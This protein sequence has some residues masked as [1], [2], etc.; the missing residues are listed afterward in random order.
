MNGIFY[1]VTALLSLT[2]GALILVVN[3]RRTINK[4]FFF[5]SLWIGIWFFCVFMAIRKGAGYSGGPADDILFWLRLSSV[6]AAFTGWFVWLM[7][8][9]L[10]DPHHSISRIFKSSWPWFCISCVIAFLALTEWFVPSDST[11]LETKRGSGYFLYMGAIACSCVYF[12]HD[13]FLQMRRLSGARKIEM[14]LFLFNTICACFAIVMLNL[15]GALFEIP[16]LRRI[17]PFGFV[18]LH[19][20]TVWAVS[21]HKV[22]DAK[23]IVSSIGQRALFLCVLGCGAFIAIR[24][25]EGRIDPPFDILFAAVFTGT[26]AIVFERPTRKWFGLDPDHLLANPRRAIIDCARNEPDA[27]E[28]KLRF[29]KV[30]QEWCQANRVE[31][32]IER[33]GGFVGTQKTLS[34]GWVMLQSLARN[35]WITPEFLQRRRADS[36]TTACVQWMSANKCGALLASPRGSDQPSLVIFLGLRE[37]LRPYTY[38]DIQLIFPLAELMDNILTHASLAQHAAKLAQME[39]AAMMSR[40]LAHDLR[41]LT[42]PIAA[43]LLCAEG[44]A[45]SGSPEAEVYAAAR[46]SMKVMDDYIRESLFFSRRL[47][48]EFTELN[49]RDAMVSVIKLAQDRAAMRGVALSLEDSPEIRFSADHAL[50]ERLTL[51]LVHNAVDASGYGGVVRISSG[52]KFE[53]VYLRVEDQGAGIPAENIRRIFDPYFTTKDTGDTRRGL[54]LGLAICRKIVDLHGGD[55]EVE[56]TPGRGATFTALFP[57][58]QPVKEAKRPQEVNSVWNPVSVAEIDLGAPSLDTAGT[59]A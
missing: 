21:S 9:V 12:L 13:A 53:K 46:H 35:S 25:F 55:I 38:P 47:V 29:E 36:A 22:F 41:N 24:I 58:R 39:S 31:L 50:F 19:I 8:S 5:A 43:Y 16:W 59:S 14:Q 56:S 37:S 44:R 26:L 33:D 54:G 23:Q 30:I 27:A 2:N 15:G 28:L 51:N 49:P 20:L 40:S 48:P 6:V 52:R 32:L 4:M 10:L 57:A 11:P 34:G 1:F 45:R 17:G 18:A 3:P 7:R 42:T